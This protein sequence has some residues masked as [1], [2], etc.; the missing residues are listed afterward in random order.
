MLTSDID[1][2]LRTLRR[3]RTLIAKHTCPK[4]RCFRVEAGPRRAHL[5]TLRWHSAAAIPDRAEAANIAATPGD[6]RARRESKGGS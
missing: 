2:L 3:H 5:C 4:T 6:G 1:K